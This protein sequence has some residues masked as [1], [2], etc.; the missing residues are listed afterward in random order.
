MPLRIDKTK[1]IALLHVEAAKA[2][3]GDVDKTWVE[4]I[5]RLSQLCEDGASITHIAFLGTVVLAKSMDRSADLFAIKPRHAGGNPKA[6]SARILCENAL[7][8]CAAEL[9]ISLG[10]TGRQPLNNQPYFR[11]NRLGDDTPVHPGGRAAFEYMVSLVRELQALPDEN[12]ARA[13]LR[14]FIDVR[15]RYQRRYDA[16]EVGE[17]SPEALVQAIKK[18]VREN[19]E[20]GR[21]AQAVVAGL[22]DTFAGPER[23]ESGR[24][25]DPS[26]K[27]PGDVCVRLASD[28]DVWEK[29]LEVRDKRVSATDV[30]V[31]AKKCVDMDVREA[32][33][34][35]V[36]EKQ[37]PLDDEALHQWARGFGIGLT[38]FNGWDAIVEQALF[39]SEQP[40]PV[41]A[42]QA[43]LHI[44][45]RL[46]A[47]E[48]SPEA[49]A[50]W[51]SL[52]R[53]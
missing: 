7:V 25:N 14:A 26:R 22:M 46:K 31:F 5:E 4:K 27:Y 20:G 8:P 45:K 24:I 13:A 41:A 19:S 38:L 28:P 6:F 52:I 35:M 36:S 47:V 16:Y 51:Q 40:K 3:A 44:H 9:G 32:A 18:L 53:K 37:Q 50:L 33:I 34:V 23:V 10:V 1:A 2:K 15:S 12:S 39:W 17:V 49:I 21:R 48:V 43:A 11:M 30:Q 42:T 29:A